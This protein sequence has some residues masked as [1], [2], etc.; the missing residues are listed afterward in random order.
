MSISSRYGGGSSGI[1]GNLQN[2]Q[3]SDDLAE[4]EAVTKVESETG[5]I[6][7]LGHLK[8]INQS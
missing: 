5:L 8:A 6:E 7:E 1:S 3:K 4:Y 2:Q